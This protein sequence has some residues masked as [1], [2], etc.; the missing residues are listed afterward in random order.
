MDKIDTVIQ[1]GLLAILLPAGAR[2]TSALHMRS[3]ATSRTDRTPENKAGMS[4][5][6]SLVTLACFASTFLV[7]NALNQH[8]QLTVSNLV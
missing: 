5:F 4:Q 8:A 6:L 1:G 3:Y 7:L 2:I